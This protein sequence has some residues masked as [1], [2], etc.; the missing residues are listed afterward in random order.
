[1]AENQSGT[2]ASA[3][4]RFV[5]TP[6]DSIVNRKSLDVLGFPTRDFTVV[7][8]GV[9]DCSPWQSV[10]LWRSDGKPRAD[11]TARLHTMG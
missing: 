10:M 11:P 4:V 2:A 8:R 7:P 3:G 9:P 5:E 6:L 1:M